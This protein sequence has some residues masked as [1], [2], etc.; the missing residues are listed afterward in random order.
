MVIII[1]FI[2]F[3][4][5]LR[6]QPFP[7]PVSPWQWCGQSGAGWASPWDL[8]P[9]TRVSYKPQWGW[10]WPQNC[11]LHRDLRVAPWS[12][13][14]SARTGWGARPVRGCGS[15][16]PKPGCPQHRGWGGFPETHRATGPSEAESRGPDLAG[17]PTPSGVGYGR[18]CSLRKIAKGSAKSAISTWTVSFS[19]NLTPLPPLLLIFSVPPQ[20]RGTKDAQH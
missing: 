16:A 18:N 11:R 15:N 2:S 8:T 19:Q 4:G 1:V 6:A 13:P 10:V 17:P 3:K 5:I 12:T 20:E 14:G 7:H 9:A